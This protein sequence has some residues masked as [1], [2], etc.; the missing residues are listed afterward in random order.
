M[1][2]SGSLFGLVLLCVIALAG[3]QVMDL[4]GDDLVGADFCAARGIVLAGSQFAFDADV[5]ALLKRGGILAEFAPGLNL[6]PFHAL[7][8]LVALHP[9]GLGG[10]GEGG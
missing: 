2:S 5:S 6:V 8:A 1:R 10:E 7:L 3:A 9:R 4:A